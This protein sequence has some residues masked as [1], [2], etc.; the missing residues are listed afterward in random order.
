MIHVRYKIEKVSANNSVY[1]T[2]PR[3]HSKFTSIQTG[4]NITVKTKDIFQPSINCTDSSD[5][6]NSYSINISKDEKNYRRLLIEQKELKKKKFN[7]E[8]R[9]IEIQN[10]LDVRREDIRSGGLLDNQ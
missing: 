2:V 10:D 8:N 4:F 6:G 1:L 3:Q 5:N 7:I 9:L